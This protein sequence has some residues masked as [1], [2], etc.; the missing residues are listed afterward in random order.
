MNDMLILL[1]IL[2]PVYL[3]SVCCMIIFSCFVT[4]DNYIPR[5]A[6]M[7]MIFCPVVNTG[8]VLIAALAGLKEKVAK[9]KF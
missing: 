2:L 8:L 3:I 1:C 6:I 9:L 4:L 7:I 5:R